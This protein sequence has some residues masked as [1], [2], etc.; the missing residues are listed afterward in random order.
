M[1]ISESAITVKIVKEYLWRAYFMFFALQNTM[2]DTPKHYVWPPQTVCLTISNMLFDNFN[3]PLS[4]SKSPHIALSLWSSDNYNNIQNTAIFCPSDFRNDFR[5][6]SR[7]TKTA[8]NW[9]YLCT[10]KQQREPDFSRISDKKLLQ[11]TDFRHIIAI[12]AG[13]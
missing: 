3:T 6:H 12:F 7:D 1:L 4:P 5:G 8:Q 9:L 11:T 13:G 2:P 10:A